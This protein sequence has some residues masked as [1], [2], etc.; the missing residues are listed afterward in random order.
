[1]NDQRKYT[2]IIRMGHRNSAGVVKEGDYITV[3]E[4]LDGANASFSLDDTEPAE[5]LAFSRNTRLSADNNLRGFYDFTRT[6]DPYRLMPN[7]IYYGEWLVKHKVDYGN[8]AGVFYLFDI[9]DEV[10]GA[11]APTDFVVAESARLGLAIAPILYAGPYVSFEHLQALVGRSALATK[12]DA[13]E[14]IVVKNAAF[15]DSFGKQTFVKLVSDSFREIQPQKAPLDP[16]VE[17]AESVFVKT[18]MTEG[19]VDKLLRKLVDESVIPESF[20]LE[21]MGVILR[22]LSGRVYDDLLKEESDSL[23]ENFEENLLRRAIGKSL[24]NTIKAI[25]LKEAV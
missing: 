4:K 14:G 25:I 2:D 16:N 9:Y 3:Y 11:Y 23:P 8:N 20:G 5:V 18:F 1:M 15:R 24:P 12:P 6:V 21:D 17:T 13:G 22:E 7:V 19:R 10:E